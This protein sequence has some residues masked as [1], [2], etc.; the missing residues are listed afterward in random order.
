MELH[1]LHLRLITPEL[2]GRIPLLLCRAWTAN[3]VTP[4]KQNLS[5][6]LVICAVKVDR[7]LGCNNLANQLLA[8][9]G[10]PE[11]PK[12]RQIPSIYETIATERSDPNVGPSTASLASVGFGVWNPYLEA[13]FVN[14]R[15]ALGGGK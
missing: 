2:C 11:S 3:A 5:S 6:L 15:C 10:G 14:C 8:P 9:Q 13:G 12:I 1:L 4:R 7:E